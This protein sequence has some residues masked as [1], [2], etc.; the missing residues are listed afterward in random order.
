MNGGLAFG[1]KIVRRRV[2]PLVGA[3]PRTKPSTAKL[4]VAEGAGGDEEPR[5]PRRGVRNTSR[6]GPGTTR[7]SRR[8][9]RRGA[10][11]LGAEARSPVE[12]PEEEQRFSCRRKASWT[13]KSFVASRR[14]GGSGLGESLRIGPRARE[15][16]APV[17]KGESR[18]GRQRSI[19]RAG[20]LGRTRPHWQRERGP[21]KRLV[22]RETHGSP[23]FP[24]GNSGSARPAKSG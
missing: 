16:R 15:K 12:T 20:G 8:A 11:S 14:R 1:C 24:S 23:V 2:R 19:A 22:R 17:P 9:W 13:G 18:Q 3:R 10:T 6:G 7:V 21:P 4:R 5:E